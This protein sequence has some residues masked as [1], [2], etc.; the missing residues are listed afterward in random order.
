MGLDLYY[1]KSASVQRKHGEA[2]VR[3]NVGWEERVLRYNK[4]IDTKQK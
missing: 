3:E 4:F 2:E 1:Q